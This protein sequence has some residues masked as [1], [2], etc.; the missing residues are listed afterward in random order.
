[1]KKQITPTED[2]GKAASTVL[3][4]RLRSSFSVSLAGLLIAII[5]ASSAYAQ[6]PSASF[7]TQDTIGCVPMTVNFS[8]TS[9]NASSYFWDFGNGNTSTLSSPSNVYLQPGTY[10]V[11]LIARDTAG[12]KD[13]IIKS[14]FIEVVRNPVA[15]FTANDTVTCPGLPIIFTNNS[16]YADSLVWDFGDG[17]TSSDSVLVHN[18]TL[19]GNYTVKLIAKSSYGCRDVAV[20]TSYISILPSP[21]ALFSASQATACDTNTTIYFSSNSHHSSNYKWY[22]GDGD[23]ANTANPSHLYSQEGKYDVTLIASNG[24]GC[25]DT[26]RQQNYITI[27]VPQEPQIIASTTE[28]CAPQEIRFEANAP[29]ATAWLW[30]FGDSTTSTRRKTTK[31]YST[32]DTFYVTLSIQTA[33]GCSATVAQPTMIVIQQRP[34]AS[35]TVNDT[36]GCAP[37]TAG[38]SNLST[39]GVTS[40]WNYGDG[41]T[42]TGQNPN[43]IYMEE[44]TYD[45]TL[46]VT[47]PNGCT[48]ESTINEAV[49]VNKLSAAFSAS[50]RSGCI[51][52]T[53][54]FNSK[55]TDADTWY[56]DFGNG[57]TSGAAN[58]QYIYKKPGS[59][60]VSLIVNTATG[61]T[62][63][64]VKE[65]FISTTNI[66]T[67]YTT[68]AVKIGC[69]PFTVDF[70]DATSGSTAWSWNFGDGNTSTD[71]NP[72][73]TYTEP[74]TYDVSLVTTKQGGCEQ[75][76]EVYERIQVTGA[77]AEF[78][79]TYEACPPY[80]VQF[81]DSTVG[82][83]TWLW[84][85]DDGTTSTEQHPTKSFNTSG[86][87]S[88]SLTITTADSCSHTTYANNAIYFVPLSAA[89]KA[90]QLDTVFPKRVQFSA[91]V[92]GADSWEWDFGDGSFSNQL[93]P[94]HTY[95]TDSTYL[96]RF[97]IMNDRCT[98]VYEGMLQEIIPLPQIGGVKPPNT[99]DTSAMPEPITGCPPLTVE[100]NDTTSGATA[101][102]WIHGNGDTSYTQKARGVYDAPG[103][104][105]IVLIVTKPGGT[106]TIH[107]NNMVRVPE[108]KARFSLMQQYFCDKTGVSF[109]DQ[110]TNASQWIWSFGD[111]DSA[112]SQNPLHYYDASLDAFTVR[113]RVVD[114]FGCKSS[115]SRTLHR[116]TP[117]VISSD[118]SEICYNDTVRFDKAL[119][120]NY[121]WFWDFGDGNSSNDATPAHVYTQGG[122][123]NVMLVMR[124]NSN[125]CRDTFNFATQVNV[126][127]PVADFTLDT[128]SVA[129][130][131]LNAEFTNASTSANSY[132]WHFGDNGTS[133]NRHPDYTYKKEGTFDVT[134]IA[135]M[136]GC[137]DT[138]TVPQL[139]TI[140]KAVAGFAMSQQNDCF[141]ITATF[142]DT[143]TNPVSWLW[144]FQDGTTSA[145]QH[146]Q[147]V[148]TDKPASG[149]TL[150]ITDTNGCEKTVKGSRIDFV[151]ADFKASTTN[152]CAP[153]VISFTD[154]SHQATSWLWEFGDGDTS[155]LQNPTHVYAQN[156]TYTVTLIIASSGNCHD[157]LVMEDYIEISRPWA[158][159]HTTSAATCAPSN[160]QFFSTSSDAKKWLW[161]FGDGSS[162]TVENPA[163]IYAQPGFYTVKLKI[164]NK[165]GCIDSI[166]KDRYIRVLGPISS[167]SASSQDVCNP[168]TV[169]FSDSTQGA[170]SWEWNFGDG[171]EST[172]RHPTHLYDSS[173]NYTVSLITKDSFNCQ[174]LYVLPSK[175]NVTPT[176]RASFSLDRDLSCVGDTIPFSNQSTDGTLW[177]WDFGDGKSSSKKN[178]NHIY[179]APGIYTVTLIASTQ[180]GCADTVIKKS[181]LR[182]TGPVA[183]F[184]LDDSSGCQPVTVEFGH[185]SANAYSWNWNFGDG[186]TSDSK[187]PQHRYDSAGIYTVTLEVTDSFNCLVKIEKPQIISV[188]RM[189]EAKFSSDPTEGCA[190]FEVNFH[191]E[192]KF[193]DHSVWKF[194]DDLNIVGRDI[195]INSQDASYTYQNKGAYGVQLVVSTDE[196]CFD[197]TSFNPVIV[198]PTPAPD[199]TADK[200]QG[201]NP[202]IIQFQNKTPD[203]STYSY[204]WLLE[205]DTLSGSDPAY[206]FDQSGFF[207]VSLVATSLEGCNDTLTKTDFIEIFDQ[208]PPPASDLHA[209]SVLNNNSVEMSWKPSKA[210]DFSHYN[211]YLRNNVSGNY[212]QIA[213]MNQRHDTSFSSTGLNTLKNVYTFIVQ[214]ED[215]CGQSLEMDKHQPHST[216]EL[217]AVPQG[218]MV[219]LNWNPYAGCGIQ[220]YK[221]FRLAPGASTPELLDELPPNSFEFLDE[222]A[223]PRL[224]S[225]RIQAT[226]LCG[227]TYHSFSDTAVAKPADSI[228]TLTVD[229]VRST[230]IDDR[231]V[232]TEWAKPS[233]ASA[234]VSGFTI[235]RSVDSSFF[236]EIAELPAEATSYVDH[237]AYVKSQNY[238]YL[239]RADNRCDIEGKQGNPGSSILLSAENTED[240]N[241]LLKWSDYH[242]WKNGVE[243]FII[244]KMDEYGTWQYLEKV[245]GNENSFIDKE[246]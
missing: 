90:E 165:Q 192:S 122:S 80:D 138:V 149:T 190:P 11:T 17:N 239:V 238:Y 220:S 216:I 51:P 164:E 89:L 188:Y 6:A 129:C 16:L 74:G 23:S 113:L 245:K 94:L 45:V 4:A 182:I 130:D 61:C 57:D 180:A 227:E 40:F 193:Y 18:Y 44:G 156:G 189:P 29:G 176:P 237:T 145:V 97:T 139:V 115:V 173:G 153:Q 132:R 48:A 167:F 82:A 170:I 101:W 78:S 200:T 135:S 66:Q 7:T 58:P 221:V 116:I 111:G 32:T 24:T 33:N 171:A 174:A 110:S 107:Y 83:V 213:Q 28:G 187:D 219:K 150:K 69:A 12:N 112:F 42:A 166:I 1:M 68:P 93:S 126:T 207:D 43:H 141:P 152:G 223:C 70:N 211:V 81:H 98:T 128:D 92:D 39:P 233:V 241:V 121:S 215:I 169:V 2:Q 144:K 197:T 65:N 99:G 201:C 124:D 177:N 140:N 225:Y 224:Y 73:H 244:E 19:P 204:Q 168:A 133:H 208:V 54:N 91:E 123:Y 125:N 60:D 236:E 183:D 35:F 84:K 67:N 242:H 198:N 9:A 243:Y 114:T 64:L 127:Q 205:N 186:N 47:A 159:F 13:T 87:H 131:R 56:W 162:S 203:D 100:L 137:Y 212:Q 103:E 229:I 155:T 142:T 52:M 41:D 62:D 217:K 120:G 161:S 181:I 191:N 199:F 10:H 218:D 148:F 185:P 109:Q 8:N 49:K 118:V 79:Y 209:V 30:N 63:T 143:S 46:E 106:D 154:Q 76:I 72:S 15:S 134:L 119:N 235:F 77:L 163:H 117:D 102:Q 172:Q 27:E 151:S 96:I 160:V 22:F 86:Y 95:Q 5:N 53:V 59:Y 38:F 222:T 179:T 37:Y 240:H 184:T 21:V 85:F 20:K 34:T 202:S 226:R 231:A 232:L 88:V 146:P 195:F 157:T 14:N 136:N 36:L 230:V 108:V 3:L 158:D 26:L 228:T 25:F 31:T 206:E 178:P 104:Y 246:E 214:T 175:I 210:S 194:E 55:T 234:K 105:D 71:R 50:P 75:Y 196:G 147:H